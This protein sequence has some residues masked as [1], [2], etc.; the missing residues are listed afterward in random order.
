[1]YKEFNIE[2]ITNVIAPELDAINNDTKS[3][4]AMLIEQGIPRDV[5]TS[6]DTYP[7]NS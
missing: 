5:T 6:R 4:E 3:F 2:K 7:W 1:M